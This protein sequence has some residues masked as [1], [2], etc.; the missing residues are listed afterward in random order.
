MFLF[1][2]PLI[3]VPATAC[4][5][6]VWAAGYGHWEMVDSLD[7]SLEGQELVVEGV[8]VS[9][10]QYQ[11]RRVRFLFEPEQASLDRRKVA[12][13]SRL[14]LSWYDGHPSSLAPGQ[15][16]RLQ[17]KL[18]RPWGMM[19][20]GGFDFEGWLFAQGIHA[21]GYVRRSES[22]RLLSD[23]LWEVPLQRL[24]FSLFLRL[25]QALAEKPAAGV[26][27]ALALGE[28]GGIGDEQWSVLMESGTNHLVAISGLHVGLVAGLLFFL[29][30]FLWCRCPQCCLLLP[31][32]RAAAVVALAAGVG[33]AALAGFSLPTQRAMLMLAVVLGAKILQRPVAPLRALSLALWAVLLWQPVAVLS[34]GFWLS[35][36]AVAVILFG[37]SGRLKPAGLWWRWG[38]VQVLASVGLMPLLL[39]FFAKGSL[40]APLANLVAVPLVGFVIVPLTLLGTILLP[41][42]SDAGGVLLQLAADIFQLG[43]P[44]LVWLTERIPTIQSSAPAWTVWPGLLGM[45][46][47]LMPR[48]WPLRSAGVALLLPLLSLSPTRPGVGSAEVTLLDVGQGL[49]AVVRT[50]NHAL[51]FDTG[52]KYLSGFNTGDAVLLPYLQEQGVA[53]L[54]LLIVSHGDNDHIGGARALLEGIE[55]DRVLT[56]VPHK[57]SWVAHEKCRSG[58]EWQWDGVTFAILHPPPGTA[59]GRGNN[60]SCVLKVTAGGQSVLLPGDIE[61]EA[62]RQL[63]ASGEPLGAE[64]L[65]APHHGSKTSSSEAFLDAVRPDWVLYPV[66]YRN[67]YGFPRPAIITRYQDRQVRSLESYRTGA[68]TFLLGMGPI[69]PSGYR[70]RELRYWHAR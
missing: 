43:W 29:V 42:W 64:V 41:V 52:P 59:E 70:L 4:L 50:A 47:L 2:R 40:S 32:P 3:V 13:P 11:S 30:R 45:A 38:R 10:P 33:Y 21:T 25:Q 56:S 9:I 27:I 14:R 53:E 61:I 28:R 22:S 17:V 24:R 18:K 35:F 67:R 5:G 37:M 16:W 34:A 69:K 7:P 62:E 60:D 15:H 55:T 49:A 19:N 20:P 44:M 23:S 57:M 6:F 12:V 39:G 31:A 36:A 1:P 68:I 65:I 63:L 8:I 54:D 58:Q 26:I 51:V 48:G 46:W 66:G